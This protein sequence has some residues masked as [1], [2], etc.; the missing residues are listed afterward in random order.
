MLG[1]TLIC[2][3]GAAACG[4][5]SDEWACKPEDWSLDSVGSVSFVEATQL[6]DTLPLRLLTSVR[7]GV[8]A[9][10]SVTLSVAPNTGELEV[11]RGSNAI[12]LQDVGI[13]KATL[14]KLDGE[15]VLWAGAV[16][17][18][19]ASECLAGDQM[20]G[21]LDQT[22]FALIELNANAAPLESPPLSL[23]RQCKGEAHVT[24]NGTP[25]SLRQGT[26]LKMGIRWAS[27]ARAGTAAA[28][29]SP[30][31]SGSTLTVEESDLSAFDS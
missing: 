10:D 16:Q 27:N 15:L 9:A 25:V 19:G 14:T 31:Q 13:D 17:T 8:T 24:W 1:M 11:R 7:V 29:E 30:S 23:I 5:K 22:S 20:W 3:G 12:R 18:C 21:I 6:K 4:S 26:N 28:V 2:I